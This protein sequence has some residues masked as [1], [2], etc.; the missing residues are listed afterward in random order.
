MCESWV[1]PGCPCAEEGSSAPYLTLRRLAVWLGEPRSRLRLLALAADSFTTLQ[2]RP[3]ACAPGPRTR[4]FASM[5]AAPGL[6]SLC[7]SGSGVLSL[8]PPPGAYIPLP[9]HQVQ[10][11]CLPTLKA[12][13]PP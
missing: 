8:P 5:A 4:V 7:F 6:H 12:Q 13:Y 3:R 11:P 10:S 2:V 9:R 1:L